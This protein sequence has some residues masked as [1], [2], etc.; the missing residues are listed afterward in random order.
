MKTYRTASSG[1]G[2][3][4]PHAPTVLGTIAE[5]LRLKSASDPRYKSAQRYFK[6]QR[7]KPDMVDEVMRALVDAAVPGRVALPEEQVGSALELRELV[8]GGLHQ[9]ARRWDGFVAEVNANLFPVSTRADLAVPVLRLVALDLGIRY[10][11]WLALRE[12]I[13]GSTPESPPEGFPDRW[14]AAFIDREIAKSK[15]TRERFA[16]QLGV[17]AQ[18]LAAWRRG[19]RKGLPEDAK[20]AKIA[21]TLATERDTRATLELEI[22]VMVAAQDLHARLA[23]LCGR[24]RV[25]DMLD[26]MLLT[27]RLVNVF[28][29]GPLHMDAPS[30]DL[31]EIVAWRDAK[32]E[33][34]AGMPARLWNL[35]MHGAAC[36]IGEAVCSVLAH[37]AMFRQEV[38][39]DFVALP[40]DWSDRTRYWMRL[41][42]SV[43]GEIA[44]LKHHAEKTGEF[45]IELAE[46][47]A[48]AYVAGQ[49][50]MA[51]FDWH[52][53][54]DMQVFRVETP[55]IAK[56]TNRVVQAERARSI[57]D[58]SAAVEHM[59]YAVRH[60]PT[61]ALHHFKLGAQL[62]E[63]GAFTRDMALM[64]EGLGEL[65]VA[66]QLDPEFGNA[67]NEIGIV[68]SNMR[69]H[70]EAEAA[71]VAAEAHH[72]AHAHHWLARGNNYLG[73]KQF[74]EAR[75]AF[76]KA[77]ELSKDGAHVEAKARLAA[78]LMALGR[79]P[80]ARKIAKEVKHLV[81]LDPAEEW[82]HLIDVWGDYRFAGGAGE[83]E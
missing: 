80:E 66:V 59:R 55:P 60:E 31:R 69:R 3:R 16:E 10:G 32:D 9:Y 53:G 27:A 2:L 62:A 19:G 12:I 58:L 51:E 37:I 83:T 23:H 70:A 77:I 44:Y 68:L 20:I 81:G 82:K 39:A 17:S 33:A 49:L 52:P 38:A 64:E 74:E 4:L 21:R 48:P 22:R 18:T 54:P 50:R 76:V 29:T 63:L 61:N 26:A 8:H 73:L 79:G 45:P 5:A 40:G 35:I 75:S 47:F 43:P 34:R 24:E 46:E 78:T 30:L 72:G 6:G 56:A 65:H 71:F 67:R 28:W 14:F 13:D 7:V 25:R 15:L 57:G 36:P 1:E 11:A 42:G 41:L